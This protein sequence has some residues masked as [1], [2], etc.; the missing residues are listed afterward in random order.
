[1]YV[2]AAEIVVEVLDRSEL[3]DLTAAALVASVDRP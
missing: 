2:P 3:L 1:M